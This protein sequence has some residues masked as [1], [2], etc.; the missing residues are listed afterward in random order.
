MEL[1]PGNRDA[2]YRYEGTHKCLLKYWLSD[3]NHS[4]KAII[5]S[6]DQFLKQ[7][8]ATAH[9]IRSTAMSY[10]GLWAQWNCQWTQRQFRCCHC[11][12]KSI[13]V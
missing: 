11:L 5:H 9:G 6:G 2:F 12:T 10:C 8:T 4:V 7:M 3:E 13:A 1:F